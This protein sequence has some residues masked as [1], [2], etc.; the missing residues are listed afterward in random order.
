MRLGF[1]CISLYRLHIHRHVNRH[2]HKCKN[3]NT[4]AHTH[5]HTHTDVCMN[6]IALQSYP[7]NTYE[8]V[9]PHQLIPNE[10]MRQEKVVPTG[11][12]CYLDI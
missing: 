7:L 11:G 4:S 5:L 1:I 3:I 9:T 12:V 8:R 2:T 10:Y 6:L